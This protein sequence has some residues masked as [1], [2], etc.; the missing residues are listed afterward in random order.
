M[1]KQELYDHLSE[2]LKEYTILN[3]EAENP[4]GWNYSLKPNKEKNKS[5][6]SYG[7]YRAE[8]DKRMESV[9]T[10][11]TEQEDK[12]AFLF[13][14]ATCIA[15]ALYKYDLDIPSRD[16]MKELM[17]IA[18]VTA[19]DMDNFTYSF[20]EEISC[21]HDALMNPYSI[22]F[23][24]VLADA[25]CENCGIR[26]WDNL[27]SKK[28]P[29]RKEHPFLTRLREFIRY[30][31]EHH[32]LN[33]QFEYISS[34]SYEN[35]EEE[36][37]ILKQ[38]AADTVAVYE[39][40]MTQ[41]AV[42]ECKHHICIYE[43]IKE[44]EHIKNEEKRIDAA[45]MRLVK[46]FAEKA[47]PLKSSVPLAKPREESISDLLHMMNKG[48]KADISEISRAFDMPEE[49]V[50]FDNQ[51]E[52]N[53]RA[54]HAY[55]SKL[56]D[57]FKIQVNDIV[58]QRS[59]LIE[60]TDVYDLTEGMLTAI[61]DQDE[62]FQLHVVDYVSNYMGQSL[63]IPNFNTGIPELEDQYA[64]DPD[65]YASANT[66]LVEELFSDNESITFFDTQLK[67]MEILNSVRLQSLVSSYSGFHLDQGIYLRKSVIKAFEELGYEESKAREF[68]VC[69]AALAFARQQTDYVYMM[70]YSTF[71]G[72]EAEKEEDT[73]QDED[74]SKLKKELESSLLQRND[75]VRKQKQSESENQKL[76]HALSE[77]ERENEQLKLEILSLEEKLRNQPVQKKQIILP[78]KEE[79]SEDPFPYH[80]EK[81]IIL[82]GGFDS[83]CRSVSEMIPDIRCVPCTTHMDLNLFRNADLVFIQANKI[84]HSSYWT[85]ISTVKK[86]DVP[87]YH[88][89]TAGPKRCALEMVQEIKKLNS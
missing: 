37:E 9:L 68:A 4:F 75:A 43:L 16:D 85:V 11:K 72:D 14:I 53:L 15:V 57:N 70:L 86:A 26:S 83:F 64:W 84:S 23:C 69:V 29:S 39:Q 89:N 65:L 1:K 28:Y 50:Q 66:D 8:K 79:N 42:L 45:M 52:R 58:L 44:Y 38:K 2:E 22:L 24:K 73:T 61:L 3:F 60:S 25:L 34:G 46:Q 56:A 87:F 71:Y 35:E 41:L 63:G 12:R 32:L 36:K 7:V 67:G 19:E 33:F 59:E 76:R 82:F 30:S 74:L 88:L 17:K 47:K 13:Y 6:K 21:F 10:T 55:R 31:K 77:A 5:K 80:T 20:G 49:F 48:G 27:K 54:M 78:A 18:C 81:N 40:F 51:C 62:I